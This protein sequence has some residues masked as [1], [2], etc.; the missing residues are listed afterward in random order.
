MTLLAYAAGYD[1]GWAAEG[2]IHDMG[3]TLSQLLNNN[4]AI[5]P[6]NIEAQ[7]YPIKE[8]TINWKYNKSI[9]NPVLLK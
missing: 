7:Y 8:V 3:K 9:Q 2:D 1:V 6:I 5:A 4:A